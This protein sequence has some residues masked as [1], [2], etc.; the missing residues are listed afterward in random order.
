MTW[1]AY[2]LM[3]G[4]EPPGAPAEVLDFAVARE[5]RKVVEILTPQNQLSSLNK[6]SHL[7]EDACVAWHVIAAGGSQCALEAV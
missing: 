1:N 3:R 2:R 4:A 6:I 5:R 7:P